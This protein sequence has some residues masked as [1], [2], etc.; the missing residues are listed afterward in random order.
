MA[1]TL[2]LA[3]GG[4]MGGALLEGWLA[5][6]TPA[7]NIA[8]IEPNPETARLL[9][10]RTGIRALEAVDRIPPGFC[11]DVVIFAV[12]PQAMDDV[13][14]AYK[15][16]AEGATVF[17]SIAAGKNLMSFESLLGAD[18][19][20]VRAMPNTPAAIR[21]GITV[22]CANA[23][24][25]PERQQLC[26]GLLEAVGE[27]HW[28]EDEGLLDAVTALSGGG[29]AYVFL[30]VECLA[31][32]GVDAGLPRDLAE[33]LARVT[34]SGAGELLA[35]SEDPPDLLRRNVTSPGGTTA[36]ALKILMAEDGWQPLV[37]RAI[38]AAAARS[39]QLAG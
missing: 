29:P 2:L 37:N 35:C 21:R 9:A 4:K 5:Q 30:L 23:R 6:G 8:A 22:A 39:R 18:A 3:G 24:V 13:A 20:V 26:H 31:Q 12:K 25:G 17:L 1:V 28:V 34:V 11:P 38:A 16:F 32:A 7:E 27:V 36:E 14:P 33:R 19:A 10:D 15:R